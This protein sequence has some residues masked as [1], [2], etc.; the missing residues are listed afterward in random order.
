VNLGHRCEPQLP[1][2]LCN[3]ANFL[4]LQQDGVQF[5]I[6]DDAG[7]LPLWFAVD[8]FS[9]ESV[10]LLLN[11]NCRYNVQSTLSSYCGPCNPVEHAVH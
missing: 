4:F 6:E 10:K 7:T 2:K 8:G 1:I 9:I 11:A 3:I 5:S